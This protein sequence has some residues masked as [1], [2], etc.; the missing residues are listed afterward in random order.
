L[1]QV[2][3]ERRAQ[4]QM[5]QVAVKV[6]FPEALS[7]MAELAVMEEEQEVAGMAY[8]QMVHLVLTQMV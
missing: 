2:K 7:L 4:L 6:V 1:Q 8:L 3:V 5:V